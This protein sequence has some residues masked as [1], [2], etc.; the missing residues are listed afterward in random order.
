MFDEKLLRDLLQLALLRKFE[1][2]I[3]IAESCPDAVLLPY[4]IH[5]KHKEFLAWLV[6]DVVPVKRCLGV[7]PQVPL[8]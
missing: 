3:E 2:K 5:T 8:K 6:C 1:A 4:F 7:L